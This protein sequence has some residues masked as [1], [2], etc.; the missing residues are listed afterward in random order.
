MTEIL[1]GVGMFT[2]IVLVLSVLILFAKSLLVNASDVVIEINDDADKQ[3]R[4]PAGT[5]CSTPYRTRGSSFHP[6]VVAAAPAASAA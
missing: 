1:L 5:S 6:P 3:F 4:A 2:L